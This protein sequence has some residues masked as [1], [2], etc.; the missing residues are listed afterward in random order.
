MIKALINGQP[1][2]VV[3]ITDRAFNYGDG[4]FE[5]IAVNDR[6]LQFWSKHYQRLSNGCE[7]L[8]IIPPA[9]EKLLDDIKKLV[10]QQGKFVLKIIVSRGAGGRGYAAESSLA[11]TIV[12][13]LNHWP[14]NNQI[15]IEK[16]IRARLC[17][18][19]LVINPALAGIK[20][21]NRL[22]QVIAR[23]E[24][25]N[26]DFDE[27]IMLDLNDNLL[28]GTASNLFVKINNQWQ[29]APEKDCAVAGVMRAFILE[30]L[31]KKN[32][33]CIEK[34]IKQSELPLVD[35]VFV[36]NSIWGIIP[37]IQCDEFQF[38]IGDDVKDLQKELDQQLDSYSYVF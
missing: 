11:P 23:N 22:D 20:H 13:S 4:V 3:S 17:E 38:S 27:G 25:H 33:A 32:I 10:P 12:V 26:S 2:T 30:Q 15:R 16:G 28:E 18:H 29:T 35:E 7:K 6:K 37:V 5:T 19:R 34:R 8:S 31:A 21:L 1:D 36:C 14:E 24:W 9:E